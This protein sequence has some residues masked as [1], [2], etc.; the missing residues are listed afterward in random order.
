MPVYEYHC[1]ENNTSVEVEHS[2]H[3]RLQTWGEVCQMTGIPIGETPT[4]APVERLLYSPTLRTPTSDSKL[5]ELGF[6]KLVRRDK[7]VYE[8]VTKSGT[9]KRYMNANDPSS[10]PHI[11]KKISD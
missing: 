1:E 4:D 3:E 2:Y 5:K 11:Q 10:M 9:E 8:N 6:T 7:G